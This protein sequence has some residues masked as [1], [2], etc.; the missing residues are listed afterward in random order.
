MHADVISRSYR[1]TQEPQGLARGVKYEVSSER[2]R[3]YG[4]Q[5]MDEDDGWA[6][7]QYQQ[8]EQSRTVNMGARLSHRDHELGTG[9]QWNAE[10]AS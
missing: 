7:L 3:S 1:R 2:A 6:G 5:A 9:R 8:A 4:Q 10:W